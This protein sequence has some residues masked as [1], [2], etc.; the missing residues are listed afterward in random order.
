MLAQSTPKAL[1]HCVAADPA[2]ATEA[3][4]CPAAAL[5]VSATEHRLNRQTLLVAAAQTAYLRLCNHLRLAADEIGRASCRER[6]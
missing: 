3:V 5:F 2:P 6:V 1:A 4:D